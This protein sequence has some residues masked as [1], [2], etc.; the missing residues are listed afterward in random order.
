M[1][2]I[3]QENRSFDHYFGTFPGADG[4]PAKDGRF[5]VCVPDAVLD[6]CVPPYHTSRLVQIGGPHSAQYSRTD[7]NGGRMDGFIDALLDSPIQCGEDRADPACRPYLGPQ[8]QP[9]VMSYHD[10][11]EIPNYWTWAESFVLQDRMFAPTDSWTL[12]AHLFLVSGWSASCEDPNDPMSCRSDTELEDA[13]VGLAGKPQPLWAWTDI[14]YLLDREGVSWGYYPREACRLTRPP[15]VSAGWTPAQNPL[16]YFT[17]VHE[18]GSLDRF[19]THQ[20][21]VRQ[22]RDGT[23]PTVSW[24]TPGHGTIS[25]HPMQAR[26]PGL[27]GG[28]AY[29]TE[30]VNAVM[31]SDLWSSS[32][33]FLTW[34]DWGGFYDHVEPPRVDKNGFGLRVPALV[35]SPW[36]KPGLIDHQTLSFDAYLKFIEDLFL[37][38]QRL[39]PGTDGRPDSRPT[40]RENLEI[41]GDIRR[42]FDFDQEPLSPM[43]LPTD[44]APGPA[45]TPGG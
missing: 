44:P 14:T 34:D 5:T 6:R 27:A 45:S 40:V 7:V 3:V 2:F 30:M 32:V 24:L 39:D 35:I 11:R 28:Q 41:L 20:R 16:P 15:C 29:V 12:P 38:G 1:I 42:V 8:D 22:V 4:I 18:N 43:P 17:D 19:F 37:D 9:D 13:I 36:V 25:E 33:I 26:N 10:A 21:F 31:R 23:L